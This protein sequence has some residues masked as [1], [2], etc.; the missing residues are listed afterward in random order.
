M[1]HPLLLSFT[2]GDAIF[3]I[4]CFSFVRG[5]GILNVELYLYCHVSHMGVSLR[6]PSG[7]AVGCGWNV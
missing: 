2:I 6:D 7:V 4:S 1:F 5:C 3:P